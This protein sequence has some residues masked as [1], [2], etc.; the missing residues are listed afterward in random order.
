MGHEWRRGLQDAA[1]CSSHRDGNARVRE[2]HET[3]MVDMAV[4][5]HDSAQVR[6]W[7]ALEPRYLR[8]Q[9]GICLFGVE[10]LAKVN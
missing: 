4:G 1:R 7:A 5:D 8:Q 2:R 9:R 6:A 10:R 3:P